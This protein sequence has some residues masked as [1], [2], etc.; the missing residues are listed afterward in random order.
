MEP[1]RIT[2]KKLHGN[3]GQ[4]SG[5]PANPRTWD[6]TDVDNL[7]QSITDTPLLAEARPLLV[8]PYD[9]KYIVLGG[10]LRLEAY[11]KNKQD[12]AP[13]FVMDNVPFD[14]LKEIVMK[15]NSSFGEWDSDELANKWSD[16][17]LSSWG[18]D[19][20]G[21]DAGAE[22]SGSNKEMD[23]DSWTEDMTLR[24]R[25]TPEQ[26]DWVKKRLEGKDAKKELLTALGYY[27]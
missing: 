24:L 5:L 17:P 20:S 12:E 15:D 25:F 21:L 4:I 22:Y 11:K 19:V 10:N 14:R 26:M 8:Y 13:C 27:G 18:V 9:G 3:K 1:I 2:L 7:A 16:L 6:A 23:T